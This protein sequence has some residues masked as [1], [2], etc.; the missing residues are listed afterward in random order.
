M[1]IENIWGGLIRTIIF[2][3]AIYGVY[4]VITYLCT[5]NII[6]ERV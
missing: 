3:V 2:L 4:F 6:K 5:K 1:G